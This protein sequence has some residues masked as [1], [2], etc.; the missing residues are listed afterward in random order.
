MHRASVSKNMQVTPEQAWDA[1]NDFGGIHKYHPLVNTSPIINGKSSGLG[2]ERVC[3]FHDGNAIKERIVDY[4]ENQ[5]YSVDIIDPGKFPLKSAVA[6]ITITP[7][8]DHTTDINFAMEFQPKFGPIGWAMGKLIME[9]QF[10]KILGN[11]VDNMEA[12]IINEN[13]KLAEAI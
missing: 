3:N 7:A 11:V 8:S 10:E 13:N 6:H 5:G 9:K 12:V 2:A 4:T 1:L